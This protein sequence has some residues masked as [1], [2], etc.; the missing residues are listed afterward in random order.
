M[1]SDYQNLMNE[2]HHHFELLMGQSWNPSTWYVMMEEDDIKVVRLINNL[3]HE[4]E[5]AVKTI[6]QNKNIQNR[7]SNLKHPMVRIHGSLMGE[8]FQGQH[9]EGKIKKDL[10]L[11]DYQCFSSYR[12][13]GDV[14]I[15]YSQ[16][17]KRHIEAYIDQDEII[18]Q[19]N[20]SGHQ[21]ITGEFIIMFNGL[22]L[23]RVEIHPFGFYRWLEI[24][25]FDKNDL[26]L[27][28]NFPRVAELDLKEEPLEIIN[29]IKLRDDL[30]EIG[31]KDQND[32]IIHSKVYDYVW[33][34]LDPIRKIN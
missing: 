24:N 7:K 9:F 19:E 17:G 22:F 31:I 29:Q 30:Y 3:C 14:I 27:G 4:I 28:L 26:T 25:G 21:Y 6:N 5:D 23:D 12:K 20:I 16:L 34:D 32:N 8:D 13:W 33:Q 1:S 2:I 11:E 15:Y 18:D 10:L